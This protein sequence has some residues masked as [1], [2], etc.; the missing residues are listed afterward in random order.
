MR[1][2][3]GDR[4]QA[5]VEFALVLPLLVVGAALLLHLGLSIR[6]QLQLEHLA[7]EGARAAA[8]EPE[9]AQAEAR[10][11]VDRGG[12]SGF[13]VTVAVDAEFVEVRVE[14]TTNRVPLVPAIGERTLS[15]RAVFRRE[16][17]LG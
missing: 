10:S 15:A 14:T 12:G 1:R 2:R 11:V 7:R 17:L 5:S 3:G 8:R 9:A 6:T 13:S 4:G 16:D